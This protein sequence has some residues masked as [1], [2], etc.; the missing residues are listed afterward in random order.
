MS[1]FDII[2]EDAFDIKGEPAILMKISSETAELNIYF[3]PSELNRLAN[4]AADQNQ[5]YLKIGHAANNPVHWKR[6][7][8]TAYILIGADI[9]VWDIGFTFNEDLFVKINQLLA[10]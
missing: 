3:K 5:D 7:N 1:D 8:E 10:K 4:F 9:D 6:D 2:L